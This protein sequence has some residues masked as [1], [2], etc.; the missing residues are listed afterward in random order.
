VYLEDGTKMKYLEDQDEVVLEGWC[1]D[2]NGEIVLGFGEC[3]GKVLS[4][5]ESIQ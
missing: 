2:R 3:R 4:S 1:K 5:V